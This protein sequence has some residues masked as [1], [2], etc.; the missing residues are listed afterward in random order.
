MVLGNVTTP[1]DAD[2]RTLALDD[3]DPLVRVMQWLL[4][5]GS[6]IENGV[7]ARD[8]LSDRE[9]RIDVVVVEQVVQARAG[10]DTVS[11]IACGDGTDQPADVRAGA[12]EPFSARSPS[13]NPE[14]SVKR[15]E[16]TCP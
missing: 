15:D 11:A 3:P 16:A 12:P 4:D 8:C 1:D 14:V 10:G 9:L 7:S 2:A 5:Q 6:V 13:V